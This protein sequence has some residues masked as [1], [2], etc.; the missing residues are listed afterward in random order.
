MDGFGMLSCDR[1]Q[2][3]TGVNPEPLSIPGLIQSK[4]LYDNLP[5]NAKVIVNSLQAIGTN[6]MFIDRFNIVLQGEGTDNVHSCIRMSSNT[7]VRTAYH[8]L[9][10]L[11]DYRISDFDIS[12]LASIS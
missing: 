2:T 4:S 5:L 8:Y 12:R 1:Q 3:L 11:F 6:Y 10:G 7:F 9:D